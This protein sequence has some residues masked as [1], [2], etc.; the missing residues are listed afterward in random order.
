[1]MPSNPLPPFPELYR[2]H[3]HHVW[4]ALR[5]LGVPEALLEDAVHD[6]FVVVHRR[7]DSFEGRCTVRAWLMGIARRIA[8]RY[9]RT[10]ARTHR[11]RQ[12]LASVQVPVMD[13]DE[14]VARQEGWQA[15]QA[16]LSQ[17]D[18]RK[19]DAF[20]LGELE[21]LN[22]RELGAALGVS[23]DTA[24]SRL[25]AAR[26]RFSEAFAHGPG[27]HA[28]LAAGRTAAP[29]PAS[30]RHRVWLMLAP[31]LG[32]SAGIAGLT[33]AAWG[34]K[35]I[36]T[37]TGLAMG[38]LVAVSLATTGLR[39]AEARTPT[40]AAVDSVNSDN[41]VETVDSVETVEPV[42]SVEPDEMAKSVEAP[43]NDEAVAASSVA[44]SSV[45]ASSVATSSTAESRPTEP[46]SVGLTASALGP[47]DSGRATT[48]SP[49][50]PDPSP[51]KPSPTSPS[52]AESV[53]PTSLSA[54]SALLQRARAA[55]ARS[56]AAGALALLREH[57]TRF[58]DGLLVEER[59]ASSIRARCALGDHAEARRDARRFAKTYPGSAYL[60]ALDRACI[61]R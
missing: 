15:L 20:V 61:D 37:T 57:E 9:R 27:S 56:D 50:Q 44:A 6:V 53:T 21:R 11:R 1:M 25:R 29:V 26:A 55:L 23:P 33:G 38:G 34:A 48:R 47:A 24:Y 18:D 10:A 3:F 31:G 7:G 45:A 35:V 4:S 22:R 46:S 40:A 60:E 43:A 8:F 59:E 5:R 58:P 19:R 49:R 14:H 30:S 16:F 28:A 54:E 2:A 39:P 32:R 51:P 17:L 13:A 36:A 52:E 42:D 12:A 41:S